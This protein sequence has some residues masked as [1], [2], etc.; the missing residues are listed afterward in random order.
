MV[1]MLEAATGLKAFGIGKPN[2]IMMRAACD[3]LGLAPDE[4][5]MIGDT[6]E[7]DILGGTQLGM[8]TVLVLTGGTQ[9][10]DLARF[11]YRPEFVV[12]SLGE[13]ARV[14]NANR[15][16]PPWRAVGER[17]LQAV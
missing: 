8:H 5:V 10:D 6:M 11:A 17:R 2:P 13:F 14:M 16:L 12:E 3:E 15:W 9:P 4:C 7:T 1:A